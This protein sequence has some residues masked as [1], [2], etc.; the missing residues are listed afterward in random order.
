MRSFASLPGGD[1]VTKG[2]A[3]LE[4]GHRTEEALLVLVARPRLRGLGISVPAVEIDAPEYA[5]YSA[6]E[7]RCPQGAH[8][9][10]NSLIQRI[11]QC[12]QL[13]VTAVWPCWHL[14]WP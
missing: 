3:D 10:Y 2:L 11:R 7:E 6:I 9:A 4:Q 12:L 13:Y 8:T 1:L 5:L 14:L